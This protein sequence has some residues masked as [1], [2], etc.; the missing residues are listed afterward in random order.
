MNAVT[1]SSGEL[2]SRTWYHVVNGIRL[3]SV[4]QHDP[5]DAQAFAAGS[6]LEGIGRGHGHIRGSG[7]GRFE[8][9]GMMPACDA[10]LWCEAS[11]LARPL[12]DPCRRRPTARRCGRSCVAGRAPCRSASRACPSGSSRSTFVLEPLAA[13][14]FPD[15]SEWPEG[16]IP[17]GIA[18]GTVDDPDEPGSGLPAGIAVYQG[19]P[20]WSARLTEDGEEVA[21]V[22]Q[23]LLRLT[24]ERL[25]LEQDGATVW[26]HQLGSFA[27][28]GVADEVVVIAESIDERRRDLRM[29]RPPGRL[30]AR[31]RHRRR[32]LARRRRLVRLRVRRRGDHDRVHRRAGRPH[33]RLHHVL[34]RPRRPLGAVVDPDLRQRRARDRR[35][36]EPRA[37]AGPAPRRVLPDRLREPHR[38]RL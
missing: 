2:G 27:E 1:T 4:E 37:R 19:E 21:E 35:A 12:E 15:R 18:V 30:R 38:G 26:T 33:R 7:H 29:A 6:G 20:Q 14:D 24:D 8:D 34:A 13:H 16:E 28:V 3:S 36:L 31:P 22:D 5:P 11:A 25:E 32:G 10:S 17:D 9:S 23:G